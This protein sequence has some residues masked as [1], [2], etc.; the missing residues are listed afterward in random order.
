MRHIAVLIPVLGALLAAR[1]HAQDAS[2][3]PALDTCGEGE[4]ATLQSMLHS[5][6]WPYRAVALLRLSRYDAASTAPLLREAWA[7]PVWQ[8]RCF[9]VHEAARIGLV[10]GD[11]DLARES[12]PF[13]IRAVLR[14][15]RQLPAER[16]ERP[17]RRLL[18]SNDLEEFLLGLEIA[19]ASDVE[20]LRRTAVE[21]LAALLRNLNDAR[22]A[23]VSRRLGRVLGLDAPPQ[24]AA[25]W[26]AWAGDQKQFTLPPPGAAGPSGQA[27]ALLG[28]DPISDLDEAAFVRLR[29]YLDA[30]KQRDL[31]VALAMDCTWSMMPMI[32]EARVGADDLILFFRDI[33]RTMRLAFVA[34]RDRDNEPVTEVHAF[35]TDVQSIRRFLFNLRVTGGADYPEAVSDAIGECAELDWNTRANRQVILIGDAPP[36]DRDAATLRNLL[37]RASAAE[38]AVH[39]VHVPMRRAEGFHNGWSPERV[40]QDRVWLAQY[41]Q[42]TQRAFAEI[43]ELGGGQATSLANA[44]ELVPAIMR[45][46]IDAGWWS[47]FD[48]FYQRYVELCR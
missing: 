7:D 41:N 19:A 32:N 48:A 6:H 2:P 31:D 38:T 16:I 37:A 44:R 39:T 36:H 26:H 42:G 27:R 30:L 12:D 20:P 40:E 34:Y 17:T 3:R 21:R 23:I 22:A 9:A 28:T 5:P 35:T 47:V 29:T 25:D 24:T 14:H 45:F 46:S 10:P 15:A 4:R 11:D 33:A 1:V 8:V 13:V 18:E 43:A